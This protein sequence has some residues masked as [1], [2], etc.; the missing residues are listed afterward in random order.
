MP[1]IGEISKGNKRPL[2]DRVSRIWLACIDC[3]KQRWVRLSHRQ[4]KHMRCRDCAR[5]AIGLEE[6]GENHP[7]WHGGRIITS[8]DY[9][10]V[11]ID[12]DNFFF[13]MVGKTFKWGGYVLE[14]RL[15]M[16][17]HLG[18]CLQ[19]WEQVHHKN[20]IKDDNRIENLELTTN[21]SHSRQ[22][23]KGYR[24]GFRKGYED[25]KRQAR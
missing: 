7:F 6:R 10:A 2:N 9:I 20:G 17:K 22:H 5:K 8:D 12:R 1:Q 4:P 16:A 25:G 13:P 19:R 18:R 3:G 21:G 23:S 24:D 14:H 11:Y 15:V